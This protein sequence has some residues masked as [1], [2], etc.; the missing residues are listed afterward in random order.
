MID[1]WRVC[2]LSLLAMPFTPPS[3]EQRIAAIGALDELPPKLRAAFTPGDDFR[4]IPVPG[5]SDWLANHRGRADVR[6]VRP[7]ATQ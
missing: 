1:L 5:R 3:P 6:P 4:P 7:F 2:F